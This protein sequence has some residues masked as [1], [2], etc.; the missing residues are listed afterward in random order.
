MCA[1]GDTAVVLCP[2]G[3]NGH[4]PRRVWIPVDSC[5]ADLVCALNSGGILTLDSCCG[6]GKGPGK[7]RLVDG[8]S[9]IIESEKESA[10]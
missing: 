1:W 6:H 3:M 2:A 10:S 7:I 5:I 4:N 8:R 9:L